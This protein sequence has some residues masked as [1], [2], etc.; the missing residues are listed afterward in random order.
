MI[1]ETHA[2]YD[3]A[4]FDND[5]EALLLS[6]EQ[7]G[8]GPIVNVGA[9]L[10]SCETTLAL[11]RKYPFIYAAL[12]VHPSGTAELNEETLK[13]LTVLIHE[14]KIRKCDK[15]SC[16]NGASINRSGNGSTNNRVN[17]NDSNN[18]SNDCP[19]GKV[20]AV[21]EIGLDYYWDEPAREIQKKWFEKQ[22]L[23][24]GE[25]QLP[26]IIHSREA[27]KDTYDIIKAFCAK[28]QGG[29][30]HCY[31]YSKELAREYLNDGFL[32][33]IGGVVTFQNAKK[34]KEAVEYLPL[35]N[36]VLETDCPYLAP[37]PNRG[38][39]NSSLNLPYIVQEISRIKGIE[40][41]RVIE[42][43]RNN[44]EKLFFHS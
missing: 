38:R 24:A 2:H 16:N 9:D 36:I 42:I 34:L 4:A 6:M 39:R 8:I 31:S 25:L 15:K 32:F 14:N 23:M 28:K 13:R 21:G 43:T 30:I 22:L 35:E 33:G 20:V 29:I 37:V 3:D 12:G 5:R 18:S 7:N 10:E 11:S 17:V 41:E 27:A 1:F 19:S 26:V 44:A 40:K